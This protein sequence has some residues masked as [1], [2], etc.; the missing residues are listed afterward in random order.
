MYC[1]HP[2]YRSKINFPASWA[3]MGRSSFSS[4]V[5]PWL[6]A[7]TPL[8]T[9]MG[10]NQI[11]RPQWIN[12]LCCWL[13]TEYRHLTSTLSH[14]TCFH[15]GRR[16]SIPDYTLHLSTTEILKI[17]Q[18]V[19]FSCLSLCRNPC[20]WNFPKDVMKKEAWS[21]YIPTRHRYSQQKCQLPLPFFCLRSM[22]RRGHIRQKHWIPWGKWDRIIAR[23][24]ARVYT[25]PEKLKHMLNFHF[26]MLKFPLLRRPAN[27]QSHLLQL[28]KCCIPTVLYCQEIKW[29]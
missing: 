19:I 2:L 5:R 20:A 13:K 6:F 4:R 27:K 16:H 17:C 14:Y 18:K 24:K 3:S 1:T 12:F 15:N 29:N 23:R 7:N 11:E 26:L 21:W 22:Q 8:Y 25:P 28:Y 10:H 9:W